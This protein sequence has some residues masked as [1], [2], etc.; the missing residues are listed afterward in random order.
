V[1][2]QGLTETFQPEPHPMLPPAGALR[3][4]EHLP[5]SDWSDDGWPCRAGETILITALTRLKDA[6]IQAVS[7]EESRRSLPKSGEDWAFA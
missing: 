1:Q 2:V 5:V 4:T 6:A 3:L 7:Q